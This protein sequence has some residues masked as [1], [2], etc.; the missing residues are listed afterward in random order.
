[1]HDL[2]TGRLVVR[3][4]HSFKQ[5]ANDYDITYVVFLFCVLWILQVLHSTMLLLHSYYLSLF[6]IL[7]HLMIELPGSKHN[8]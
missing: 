6:L 1:M 2:Q 5:I 8:T 7:V 3:T 4:K